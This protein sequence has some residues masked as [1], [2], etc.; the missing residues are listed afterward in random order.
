MAGTSEAKKASPPRMPIEDYD[1]LSI[2]AILPL[3]KTLN[4]RELKAV[5]AYEKAGRNRVTLLRA[6]RKIELAR[7]A[8]APRRPAKTQLTV[9]EPH[10]EPVVDDDAGFELEDS[11][12]IVDEWPAES[13]AEA[14]AADAKEARPRPRRRPRR[15]PR[16]S[17]PAEPARRPSRP[18]RPSR[19]SPP[20]RPRRPGRPARP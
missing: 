19:P 20:A 13:P 2:K 8:V 6:V 10:V 7:E 9:V 5:T 15:W 17:R 4:A 14:R 18:G 1:G 3:L 16:P 11:D 12:F